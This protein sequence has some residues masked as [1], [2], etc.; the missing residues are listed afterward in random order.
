MEKNS[1]I[2]IAGHTGL[3]GSSIV[4]KLES[5][6]YSNFVFT[7]YPQFDLRDQLTV[8]KFFSSVKPEYVFLAAAKVGGI[9]ANDTYP[10][11][12]AYDNLMIQNNIIHSSY[13]HNVKKLLFL[14]SSCI[15]PKL[16]PQPMKEEYLLTGPLE[17]TN[18]AYAIAKISGL[19]LC[20]YYKKQYNSDFISVMPTN[21]YGP[22]DNYNLQSSHVLPAFIRKFHLARYL[23][24]NDWPAL[25]NDLQK[26]PID[27]I[28]GKASEAQILITLERYGITLD[29][30]VPRPASR[31]TV[32]L[33]GSG[34]V[35][36]EFMHVDDLAN[37]LLFLMN[38]YSSNEHINIGTG[39]DCLIIE[40]AGLIKQLVGFQGNISWDNSKPDGTPRKL[41]SVEKL[42]NLGWESTISLEEG[43]KMV[44]KNY[45]D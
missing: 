9:M 4:R 45:P 19:K 26:R 7:P 33:W 15:Y 23:E 39:K 14:G 3:V 25:R 30:R 6:G 2:Y 44:I 1:M 43:L 42:K 34:Q 21:L 5:E 41:L 40:L 28:D 8:E 31:V 24:N 16:C 29:S 12:F 27:G 20:T 10:A 36:R 18:E 35:Y 32:S 22:G 11:E 17:P 38:T 37:A 13:Q